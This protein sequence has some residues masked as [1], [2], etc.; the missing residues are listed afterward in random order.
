MSADPLARSQRG[1]AHRHDKVVIDLVREL[2]REAGITR[3][4]SDEDAGAVLD[5]F[6]L[7]DEEYRPLPDEEGPELWA[8]LQR[9]ADSPRPA[10][11]ASTVA[12]YLR[13]QWA[14]QPADQGTQSGLRPT[15]DTS[16]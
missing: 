9:R 10:L 15:P 2:A 7:P 5:R 1:P 11:S 4:V 13:E 8:E 3:P 6:R 16:T 12:A 14:N